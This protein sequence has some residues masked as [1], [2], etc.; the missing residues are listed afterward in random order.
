M[1]TIQKKKKEKKGIYKGTQCSIRP[2][3]ISKMKRPQAI[4][5]E[6]TTPHTTPSFN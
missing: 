1:A 3:C 2:L 6:Y 5:L 4:G